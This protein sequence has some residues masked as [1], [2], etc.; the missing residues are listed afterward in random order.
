MSARC[1][2]SVCSS[3]CVGSWPTSSGASASSTTLQTASV[4][5]Y[6]KHSPQPTS[7]SSV[8]MR[9]RIWRPTP[10]AHGEG[11]VMAA[12]GMPSGTAWTA[13]IFI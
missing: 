4:A 5:P 11:G 8:A 1:I 9:T 3:I 10:G 2:R 13:V 7:P 6:A 12:S